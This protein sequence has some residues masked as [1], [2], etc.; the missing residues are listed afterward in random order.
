MVLTF[1]FVRVVVSNVIVIINIILYFI[2][3]LYFGEL[4]VELLSFGLSKLIYI[5]FSDSESFFISLFL[6][7]FLLLGHGLVMIFL[8]ISHLF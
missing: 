1:L 3:D 8:G 5:K 2:W 4:L 7:I 6:I